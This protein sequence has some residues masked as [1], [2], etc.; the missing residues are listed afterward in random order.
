[1]SRMPAMPSRSLT[2]S[3]LAV[4]HGQ[5]LVLAQDDVVLVADL[6]LAAGILAHQHVVAGL[7]V[8][9]RPLALVVQLAWADGDDLGLLR[10]LLGG[11]GDGDATPHLLLLLDALHHHSVVQGTD[12]QHGWYLLELVD[13]K[14][15]LRSYRGRLLA[16]RHGDC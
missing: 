5:D 11:V 8:H 2:G 14:G 1:M 6:D 10:L 15:S 12:V 9:G 16:L 13:R 3:L 4:D 7:D